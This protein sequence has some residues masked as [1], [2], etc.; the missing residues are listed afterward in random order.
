M[1]KLC[2]FLIVAAAV[3]TMGSCG[4]RTQQV[5]FD[6]GDSA[7]LAKGI[8]AILS[9]SPNEWKQMSDN[10]RKIGVDTYANPK[11]KDTINN[12]ITRII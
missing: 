10:S 11:E 6:N 1:N 4:N 7:D 2:I 5:P 12:F 3:L 8:D 9:L